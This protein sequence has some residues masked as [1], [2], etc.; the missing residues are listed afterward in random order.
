M[1]DVNLSTTES[2]KIGLSD[3]V[4]VLS[5]ATSTTLV[6]YLV[7]GETIF[8]SGYDIAAV[9]GDGITM[10][11]RALSDNWLGLL[12]SAFIVSGFS[13]PA[14]SLTLSLTTGSGSAFIGGRYIS[15]P[16]TVLTFSPSN[17]SYI[18][19]K[20]TRD[21]SLN[22]TGAW[23]EVNTTAIDPT[24]SLYIGRAVTSV[25]AITSTSQEGVPFGHIQG[26]IGPRS[27]AIASNVSWQN[28]VT[29]SSNQSLSGIQYYNTFTL[30][31]GIILTLPANSHRL[32]LIARTSITINGTIAAY[33]AGSSGGASSCL[34][35]AG[36]PGAHGYTQAGGGGSGATLTGAAGGSA[37]VHNI[38]VATGGSGGPGAGGSGGS[39]VQ[40]ADWGS[41]P[42]NDVMGG[43][44]G[45][46]GAGGSGCGSYGGAGGGS[47]V[48]IAPTIIISSAAVLNTSGISGANAVQGAGGGGGAGNI[49]IMCR[50]FRNVGTFYLIGGSGG[51]GGA[52]TAGSGAP[53]R[54]QILIY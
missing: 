11:E 52:A 48:L 17:N 43:A 12:S 38:V 19:L 36:S 50:S 41:P 25:G 29:I 5:K 1:A 32:I 28:A 40:A 20:V 18:F 4:G 7:S 23:F 49:Y 9:A 16:A 21:A 46:G 10:T 22:V 2:L 30:N 51:R 8:P 54:T 13:I 26:A 34:S 37:Y 6:E 33:G 27:T 42:F 47:I 31:A 39:A 14:S 3:N 15:V 35:V 45:G 24:D 44:G 53:G